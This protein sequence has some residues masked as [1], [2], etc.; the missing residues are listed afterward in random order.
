M[1]GKESQSFVSGVEDRTMHTT[2][3]NDILNDVYENGDRTMHTTD[4][5]DVLNDN[6]H[7]NEDR[8]VNIVGNN[9][10]VKLKMLV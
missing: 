1:K 3:K 6:V 9:D 8:T 7:K 10:V 2:D 5:N 4:A